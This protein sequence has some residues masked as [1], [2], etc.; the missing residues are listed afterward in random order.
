MWL[1]AMRERA[2]LTARIWSA[3]L[4]INMPAAITCVK[5]SG[6]VSQLVNASSG[7]HPRYS[8]YYIRRVRVA[9]T[10]PLAHLLLAE[11]VPAHPEVG[12]D[13]ANVKTIVFEFPVQSPPGS[14]LRNSESAIEQLEY[15][16]MVQDNWCEH[17]ASNTI[18]VK[19]HEWM[20][21]AKWVWD[22]FD[23]V[24]GLTFLPYDG[25]VYPLAPYE[26]IDREEYERRVAEM[27]KVD[28]SKLSLYEKD[29]NT[30]GSRELACVSG[31]CELI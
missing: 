6:T 17:N 5:P 24:C 26:E 1:R 8:Q 21:V 20:D 25:G 22:N 28:F 2:I 27:P 29:D 11:G 10:D 31:A 13:W 12:E 18:Y 30:I 14:V 19:D 9:A 4:G 15:F 16:K 7:I 23:N 3:A